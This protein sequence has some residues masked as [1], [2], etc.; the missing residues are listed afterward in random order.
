MS[1]KA[2]A[3]ID[4][5]ALKNNLEHIRKGV[6]NCKILAMVKRNAY[7]HG[8][9]KVA[10]T[11]RNEIEVFGVACLDEAIELYEAGIAKPILI[12]MGFMDEEELCLID[13]YGFDTVVHNETQLNV[14]EKT[15]LRHKINVWLK[16][17]TGMHRLG[18][19]PEE[20]R[21][22]YE[23]LAQSDKVNFPIHL[24][25]HFSDADDVTH[26]K[27]A[28]QIDC[29]LRAVDGL[30]AEYSLANSSAILNWPKSHQGLIRPGILLYGVSPLAAPAI[31][32]AE[33]GITPVMTL[34]SR[35]IAIHDL[36]KGDTVGYGSTW[37][38]PEA[39]RIGIVA[40]GYGDGY[41]RGVES[42]TPVLVNGIICPLIGRVAMD[43]I[44]V[45]LRKNPQAK[46][47][48][49]VVLWGKGLPIET[50]ALHAKTVP[51]ELLC[52]LTSRVNY[53]F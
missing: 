25:T 8:A 16:V 22:V 3:H 49:E 29:F 46:I 15:K 36:S 13:R 1:H 44:T 45:D 19:Q 21:K 47:G 12:L 43:M 2:I 51:Y 24:M 5:N 9:V 11:L 14:L 52:R 32:G 18:F 31:T 39:M 38:C 10:E 28:K 42:G 20:V 33:L 37:E 23:R 4:L 41:P 34:K 17:D 26:V 30:A 53:K 50:I 40:I 48:D 27:T 35:L 7:G 6:P